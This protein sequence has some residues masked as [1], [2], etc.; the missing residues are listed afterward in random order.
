M[1]SMTMSLGEP[2]PFVK[3]AS[4]EEK[5]ALEAFRVNYASYRLGAIRGAKGE[6]TTL[7]GNKEN[8]AKLY[9]E[10]AQANKALAEA[11]LKV[12]E[13]LNTTRDLEAVRAAYA[14]SDDNLDD[15]QRASRARLR[16]DIEFRM[17]QRMSRVEAAIKDVRGKAGKGH[18][19]ASQYQFTTGA[20]VR[21]DVLVARGVVRHPE[22]AAFEIIPTVSASSPIFVFTDE[23]VNSLYGENFVEGFKALGYAVHKIV[24]PD[25]EDAK[26]LDVFSS[27]ADRVLSIGIDKYSVL[28]SLGGGAVANVCGFIASTLHRG[29]GLVHFPTTLLAQCDAA[30]SHKQ[31]VNAPHGKNLVGSYYAPIKIIVDPDVLQT[32]EDWLLPDG[33]GEIVK[34]ALCQDDL[35]LQMLDEYDG[36]MSDPDFLERV[37]R[38]TIE[39]KCE[40]I[41]VDP[42]EKREAVVLIY[43]H[44][45]AH[46]IETVSHRPGSLCCLSHGQ[47]VAIGCVVSAR[48]SVALG[49]CDPSVI[50]RTIDLCEKYHLPTRIPPDQSIDAIM[51]ALRKTKIYTA[52][53]CQ[54]ALLERIGRLFNVDMEYHL[55]VSD[56]VIRAATQETMAPPGTVIMGVGSS[57]FLRRKKV[58]KN[59]LIEAADNNVPGSGWTL[60]QGNAP[61]AC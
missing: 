16:T 20:P 8:E 19:A 53:G 30:I 7:D 54:F 28:V 34:H 27:L 56:D 38:R 10:L 50:Q 59:D 23:T 12:S 25:G 32:L 41:D 1:V 52:E 24:V 37:T 42:K 3:I 21:T 31:A 60:E 35:L 6:V 11:R 18:I 22:D 4:E 51:K 43:G 17:N 29:I 48:V 46:A 2:L 47:A 33:M 13:L 36:A 44:E 45:L 9:R 26:T 57:G 61:H 15:G 14:T 5:G 55:P 40:V 49:C 58:S 39:L